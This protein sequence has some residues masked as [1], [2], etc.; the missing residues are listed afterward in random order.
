MPKVKGRISLRQSEY[1]RAMAVQSRIAGQ[2]T[3]RLATIQVL[4]LHLRMDRGLNVYD[5][6][7]PPY[8]E[9]YAKYRQAHG[10]PTSPRTLQFSGAMRRDIHAAQSGPTSA[11]VMFATAQ[12]KLKALRHQE[13][14]EWFGISPNDERELIAEQ[15]AIEEELKR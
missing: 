13:I 12:N 5:S 7:M 3:L 9:G 14:D 4:N 1:Q 11:R 8:S 2:V 6:A 10:R 15:K